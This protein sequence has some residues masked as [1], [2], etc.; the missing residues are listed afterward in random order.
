MMKL[1]I[2]IF[3][4]KVHGVDYRPLLTD[5]AIDA[6]LDGFFTCDRKY[7]KI[8]SVLVLAEGDDDSVAYFEKLVRE[9]VPQLAKV[10]RIDRGA[11]QGQSCHWTNTQQ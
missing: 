5:M 3:G 6:G 10:D 1:K 2:Q 9:K 11:S 7:D 4:P 8:Q